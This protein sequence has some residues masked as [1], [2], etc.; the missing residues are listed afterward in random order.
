MF[1]ISQ[2]API[3]LDASGALLDSGSIYIGTINLNPETNPITVYWDAAGTQPATQPLKTTGGYIVRDGKKALVYINGDYSVTIR[4]KKG[5]IVEYAPN[6]YSIASIIGIL[7]SSSGSS[8]VAYLPAGTGAVL[9]DLQAKNRERVTPQDFG[10]GKGSGDDTAA[11]QLYFNYINTSLGGATAGY[12]GTAGTRRAIIPAANYV[13]GGPINL[14]SYLDIDADERALFTAKS[15]YTGALFYSLVPYQIH[16]SGG[17]F[18][19]S[20]N[21]AGGIWWMGNADYPT[22]PINLDQGKCIFENFEAKGF[23]DVFPVLV[24]RSAQ[25]IVRNFKCDR[26]I[27][28]IGRGTNLNTTSGAYSQVAPT[29]GYGGFADR[30]EIG[31]GWIASS[32]V[33]NTDF[34]AVICADNVH[35]KELL[36]VPIP[37]TGKECAWVN[38]WT[39]H[40]SDNVRYGGEP[41]SMN[42]VNF[43]GTCS[44]TYPVTPSSV[45]ITN[46]DIYNVESTSTT[47]AANI[48]S[49][50]TSIT[51]VDGSK[52]P[53][54][55]TVFI[56]GEMITYFGRAG[57][58]LSCNARNS[59]SSAHLAGDAVTCYVS[60]IIR[61]FFDV[62]NHINI[63]NNRGCPDTG[64]LLS[65]HYGF[66]N[67]TT[68]INHVN[69]SLF[70]CNIKDNCFPGITGDFWEQFYASTIIDYERSRFLFSSVVTAGSPGN[71]RTVLDGI[72]CIRPKTYRLRAKLLADGSS[73]YGQALEGVLTINHYYDGANIVVNGAFIITAN[74]VP[75]IG[76]APSS[77]S[78]IAVKFVYTN[79]AFTAGN[80]APIADKFIITPVLDV[81]ATVG[82]VASTGGAVWEVMP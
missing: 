78:T 72:K 51:L 14:G 33:M 48:T 18:Q 29:A 75:P 28:L 62:P 15:G 7:N 65:Y 60:S 67:Y 45:S 19:A 77:L 49:S 64:L 6:S 8:L 17:I 40:S 58:T 20:A 35:I 59:L 46:S 5:A 26:N 30:T 71:I 12:T 63:T 54:S 21:G 79:G 44:A 9:T 32:D 23:Q 16:W 52:L 81:S 3:F 47:L 22:N 80:T 39:N 10:A 2:T 31:P 34:D 41:G 68:M 82:S 69:S 24:N 36:T 61:F 37:R 11:L 53:T 13:I 74:T 25:M 57:N 38:A 27:H 70:K 66:S 76:G 43:M 42:P 50:Q 73:G 55:G 4:N 1:P 56:G